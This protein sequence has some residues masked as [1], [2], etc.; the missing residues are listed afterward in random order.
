MWFT[1]PT[2]ILLYSLQDKYQARERAAKDAAAQVF[3]LQ[4]GISSLKNKVTDTER[5]LP[6]L[7]EAKKAAVNGK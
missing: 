7:E 4:S 3:Q 6:A 1:K 2:C 5:Q